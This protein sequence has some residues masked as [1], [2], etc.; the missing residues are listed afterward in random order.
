M[1]PSK[2]QNNQYNYKNKY[3]KTKNNYNKYFKVN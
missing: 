3:K 1:I 2:R